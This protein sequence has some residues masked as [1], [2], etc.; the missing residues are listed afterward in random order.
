[1]TSLSRRQRFLVL[2][3][4]R[5]AVVAIALQ[6]AALDHHFGI[7]DVVGVEGSSAHTMHCHGASSGCASAASSAVMAVEDAYALPQQV[8]RPLTLETSSLKPLTATTQVETEPP[9]L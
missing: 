7:T 9:R 2:L 5:V 8:M 6:V 1:M 4:A 3:M